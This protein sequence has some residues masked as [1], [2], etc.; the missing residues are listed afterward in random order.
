MGKGKWAGGSGGRVQG[1]I[2]STQLIFCAHVNVEQQ[3]SCTQWK[4]YRAAAEAA[5]EAEAAFHLHANK[6]IKNANENE[7][8]SKEAAQR[9]SEQKAAERKECIKNK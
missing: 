8:E 5:T 3:P 2:K 4:L 9:H 7:N 1:N 6:S